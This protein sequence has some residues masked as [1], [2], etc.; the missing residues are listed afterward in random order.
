VL[1]RDF[2]GELLFPI[3]SAPSRQFYAGELPDGGQA[4]V[5]CSVSGDMIIALFDRQGNLTGVVNQE[6]P[7]PRKLLEGGDFAAV[8]DEDYQEYLRRTL[9]LSPGLII[10]KSFRMPAAMLGVYHLPQHY[11]DFL[12]K[13]DDPRFTD[14]DRRDFPIWIAQWNERSEF[15]L[16]WGNDFWLDSSGE[17]VAS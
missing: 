14:E 2:N 15:V 10:I 16:E 5:V 11:Q 4:L 6:L 8:Y 9:G 12:E 13:P 3:Q 17:V 1:Q 7:S